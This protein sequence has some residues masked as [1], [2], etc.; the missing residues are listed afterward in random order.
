[1][2]TSTTGVSAAPSTPAL[3]RRRL[4]LLAGLGVVFVWGANFAVQKALFDVMS[5][6]AFLCALPAAAGVRSLA[7]AAR[8]LTLLIL[9]AAGLERLTRGQVAAVAIA[10]AGVL[11]FLSDKPLGLPAVWSTDW[12]GLDLV[13]GRPLLWV[14]LVSAFLGWLVWGWVDEQRGVGRKAPLQYPMPLVA[15][16]VAWWATGERFTGVKIGGAAPTLAGVALAQFAT[17]A[18]DDPVRESPAQVA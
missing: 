1:M 18:A 4:A 9:H 8:Q 11:V 7:A 16:V 14:S 12:A 2:P 13:H 10:C 17:R 5:P 3:S 6:A 15:G